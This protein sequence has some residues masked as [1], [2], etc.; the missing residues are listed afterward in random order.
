MPRL[1]KNQLYG[2]GLE[3]CLFPGRGLNMDQIQINREKVVIIKYLC[4][5]CIVN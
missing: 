5:I 3:R 4:L 1:I 2:G